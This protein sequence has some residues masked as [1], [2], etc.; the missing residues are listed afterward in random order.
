MFWVEFRNPN[1]VSRQPLIRFYCMNLQSFLD[2]MSFVKKKV[3]EYA[4]NKFQI[5]NKKTVMQRKGSVLTEGR[6]LGISKGSQRLVWS[7]HRNRTNRTNSARSVAGLRENVDVR[8]FCLGYCH[9]IQWQN[10]SPYSTP[11]WNEQEAWCV[12][13]REIMRGLITFSSYWSGQHL[14]TAHSGT[15]IDAEKAIVKMYNFL[16]FCRWG[17]FEEYFFIYIDKRKL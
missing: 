11:A 15:A 8:F 2:I 5:D 6:Q 4:T 1:H 12:L 7:N 3:L 13:M 14:G 10:Q 9:R 16:I 17:I